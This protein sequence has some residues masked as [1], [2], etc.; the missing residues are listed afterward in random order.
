MS[1]RGDTR[2]SFGPTDLK[3]LHRGWRRRTEGRLA[4]ILDGVGNPFNVGSIARTAAALGVERAW[5]VAAGTSGGGGL[6]NPKAQKTAL[7]TD[8]LV[9]W[10]E[11]ETPLEALEAA[12]QDGFTVVGIELGG[13]AR[14]LFEIE[15]GGAVC[16]AVG[17]EERGLS[18]VLLDQCDELA[19]LPLTGRVGSLN[20][21]TATAMALYEVRRQE[22][23]RPPAPQVPPGALPRPE[24]SG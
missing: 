8:R 18:N 21:A 7:G 10:E 1:R 23:M 20:V 3:R 9:A 11:V 2:R 4:L 6:G 22:W 5:L 12:R 14:P 16:L 19:Y 24:R 15:L 13:G 17:H